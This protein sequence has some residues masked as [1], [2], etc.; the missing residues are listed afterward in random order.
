MPRLRELQEGFAAAVLKDSVSAFSPELKDGRFSGQQRLQV[1]RN[2][3]F[4]SLTGALSAVYPV[5][6]RLVGIGFFGNVADGYLRQHPAHSGNLHDVGHAFADFLQCFPAAATLP[7]LADVAHLEWA[8]HQALHAAEHAPLDPRTLA[9]IAPEC[10]S[11]LR[12]FLH[13][14]ARL[15]ASDYP[16][17]RIWQANQTDDSSDLAVDLA[18][19]GEQGLVLRPHMSVEI[20]P[21][22]R[23]EYALLQCL[24][25]GASLGTAYDMASHQEPTMDLAAVLQ[26]H[27]R[28]TSLV[29]C[30]LV[31]GHAGE[32]HAGNDYA[33][34]PKE[35]G[36]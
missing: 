32:S 15:V 20:L 33:F 9:A 18:A 17:L 31:E 8:W 3:V 1:Y 36:N 35:C 30:R 16:I 23:G 10:Q 11:E 24:A 14:T 13:P 27:M 29:A 5:V 22:S 4:A 26:K 28:L 2:N 34:H 19:G 12:F 25:A 7:Y 21:L 6:T